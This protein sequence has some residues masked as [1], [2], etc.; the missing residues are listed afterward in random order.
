MSNQ[1]YRNN[2]NGGNK[3]FP[4]A[5]KNVYEFQADTTAL[6]TNYSNPNWNGFL[7][8]KLNGTNVINSVVGGVTTYLYNPLPATVSEIVPSSISNVAGGDTYFYIKQGG[9]YHI[10]FTIVWTDV[11]G[12]D[13]IGLEISNYNPIT[14]LWDI[15]SPIQCRV[16]GVQVNNSNPLV[17]GLYVDKILNPSQRLRPVYKV[18]NSVGIIANNP[19]I[20]PSQFTISKSS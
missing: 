11:A 5:S 16:S 1:V 10:E 18:S 14:G 3:Y 12:T 7:F 2:Y 20:G 17:T 9:S 6:N 15:Q 8:N 4:E 13:F 19:N